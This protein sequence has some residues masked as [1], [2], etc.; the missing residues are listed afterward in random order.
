M[1][2]G[3]LA[4][5]NTGSSTAHDTNNIVLQD[6]TYAGSAGQD[7]IGESYAGSGNPFSYYVKWSYNVT[8]L[9]GAT[10]VSGVTVTAVAT[11]GGTETVSGTTNSS[12]Q[13]TLVLTNHYVTGTTAP[14]TQT[15]F[16]PHNVTYSGNGCSGSTT[17][18][19]TATTSVTL[20]CT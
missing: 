1:T 11:G 3:N 6:N 13:A 20:P 16:T 17:V 7:D 19:I 10:P 14:G 5:C 12:G 15:N 4:Y 18:N 8:V 9:N 2:L